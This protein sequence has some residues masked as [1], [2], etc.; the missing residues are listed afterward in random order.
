M[1]KRIATRLRLGALPRSAPTAFDIA[2]DAETTAAMRDR[3]GLQALRKLRLAGEIAP[4]GRDDWHLT[5]RL[6]ATVVQPCTITLAPVTTR[7]EEEV[8]RRY[9]SDWS[10][11]E[12]PE[13]EM[14]EDETAEPLPD[15]VDL[16]A[17][18]EE[19]LAL[20]IPPFPRAPDA[21]LGEMSARPPGAAPVEEAEENPFAALADLKKR[22]DG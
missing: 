22:L 8:D 1:T 4:S 12:E 3:L 7:I 20:A 6:G 10:E 19:T 18:F 14:P 5:A 13:A 15:N 17:L 2:P 9:L 11:P 21:E 16:L